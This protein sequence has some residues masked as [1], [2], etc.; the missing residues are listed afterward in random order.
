MKKRI[1]ILTGAVLLTLM[2]G[3]AG[4]FVSVSAAKKA[5]EPAA[6]VLQSRDHQLALYAGGKLVETYPQVRV[7][8]LP[9]YDRQLLEKGIRLNSRDEVRTFLQDYDALS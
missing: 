1:M 7:D 5:E 8:D 9:E 2:I 6:Y 4:L 3:L